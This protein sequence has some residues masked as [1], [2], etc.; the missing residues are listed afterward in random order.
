[1]KRILLS[2][3]VVFAMITMLVQCG[4]GS[5][6]YNPATCQELKEKVSNNQELTENDYKQMIDQVVGIAKCL[7]EKQKEFA[8]DPEKKK[9]YENTEEVK[10]M[11]EY[12]FSFAITLSAKRSELSP[13]LQEKMNE[14][15]KEINSLQKE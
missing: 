13:S 3:V 6:S 10:Q 2:F 14:A 8:N 1:M 11:M 12:Y 4:G 9:E 7:S 15:E 5:S